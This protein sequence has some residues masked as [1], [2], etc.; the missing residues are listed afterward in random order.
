MDLSDGLRLDLYRRMLRIRRVEERVS[1]LYPEQEIRCPVHLCIGSEAVAVGCCHFLG[2]EDVVFGGHRSHGIYLA[3]G[4]SLK[5][6][7]AEL[8]GR[9]TGCS[10]GRGG[11]MHLIDESVGFLGSVP[12]VGATIPVAV[13]YA[14]NQRGKSVTVVFFGDGACETGAFFESLNLASLWKLPVLFVCEDNGLSVNSPIF[15][16]QAGNLL[17]KARSFGMMVYRGDGA[18]LVEVLRLF[19]AASAWTRGGNGPAF[20]S[21]QTKRLCEHCGPRIDLPDPDDPVSRHG[22]SLHLAD[23]LPKEEERSIEED[24]ARE[25][26]EA[27]AFAKTSPP[28]RDLVS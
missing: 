14:L 6:L 2:D 16:R 1:R 26:D 18:D 20:L 23:V 3:K 25:I 11:S 13:G 8:H 28:A 9:E 10:R 17:D 5:G 19:E 27:V 22:A 12:I 15:V 4:G 7:L 21:F 24:I